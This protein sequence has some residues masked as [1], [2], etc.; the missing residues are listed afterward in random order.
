MNHIPLDKQDE[1]VKRFF[2]SLPSAA[3]WTAR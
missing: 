3:C 1:A 2:L